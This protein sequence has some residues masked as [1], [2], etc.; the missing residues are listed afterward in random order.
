[1]ETVCIDY[2]IDFYYWLL[3]RSSKEKTASGSFSCFAIFKFSQHE[4]S[5]VSLNLVFHFVGD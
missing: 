2:I 3:L 1:M 5:R 4:N